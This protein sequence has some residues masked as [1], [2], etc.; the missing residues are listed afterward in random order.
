MNSIEDVKICV[1]ICNYNHSRY[2]KESIQS[3]VDQ[4]HKNL[5]IAV[6]DDGSIDQGNVKDLVKSFND[7]RIR[8][9]LLPTN[10]GKWNA[11]NTAFLGTDAVICTSHDADDVSL[12]WR[13]KAQINCMIET[14]TVHNLCGFISCWSD[15]EVIDY[16]TKIELPSEMKVASGDAVTKSVLQGFDT[17]GINHYFTGNFETAG[18]SSMF[19]KRIWDLGIRFL[20][21]GKNVRVLMSEDSDFNFR[22]TTSHRSTSLLLETPYLYRR[23]TSTNKEEK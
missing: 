22:L 21:P 13:L 17:P 16:A 15:Q 2:L 12:P 9:I 3:I 14:K 11:L 5:D 19:Y 23:N 1:A 6:I 20:P 18:V 7:E 4:T 10:K 8:L